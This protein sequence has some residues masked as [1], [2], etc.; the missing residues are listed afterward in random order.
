MFI[1]IDN[2]THCLE[3]LITDVSTI[4][5]TTSIKVATIRK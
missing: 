5:M 1:C 4:Q 3:I 2:I